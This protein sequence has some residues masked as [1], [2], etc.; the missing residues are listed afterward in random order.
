[1]I[2]KLEVVRVEGG[3]VIPVT[4]RLKVWEGMW[5]VVVAEILRLLNVIE[6]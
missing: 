3:F 1:M 2:I 6:F 4:V 5:V